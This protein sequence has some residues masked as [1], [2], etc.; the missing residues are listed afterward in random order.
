ME[1]SMWGFR[2]GI[3]VHSTKPVL[4]LVIVEYSM[5]DEELL[6]SIENYMYGLNPCYCGI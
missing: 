2:Y 3:I 5:W 6:Q 4:I 1:Y